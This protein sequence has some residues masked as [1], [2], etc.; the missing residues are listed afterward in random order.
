MSEWTQRVAVQ[1]LIPDPTTIGFR[2]DAH[3][4]DGPIGLRGPGNAVVLG[5]TA[6]S[7]PASR[8]TREMIR[9]TWGAF[10]LAVITEF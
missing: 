5:K 9:W 1:V 3:A 4:L 10:V 6:L 7:V 8:M 2:L